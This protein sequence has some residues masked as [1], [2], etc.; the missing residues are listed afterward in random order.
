MNT[1]KKTFVA[2]AAAATLAAT[3]LPS[4]Q[5]SAWGYSGHGWGHSSYGYNYGGYSSHSP[6][7]YS[8]YGHNSFGR[9]HRR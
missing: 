7:G 3:A 6:Y 8:W 2:I 5:A 9:F 4:T 1:F